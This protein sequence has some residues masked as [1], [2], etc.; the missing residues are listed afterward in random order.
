MHANADI[1]CYLDADARSKRVR[2]AGERPEGT[3]PP[4][5]ARGCHPS[6]VP[7][8]VIAQKLSPRRSQPRHV[9]G[10]HADEREWITRI[11]D[12]R[13]ELAG[14]TAEVEVVDYGARTPELSL[15][16]QEMDRGTAEKRVVGQ[17]C[18]VAANRRP[19]A[20]LLFRLIRE[21]R[22]E[23][24]LQLGTSLGIS[25]AYQAAALEANGRGH[26]VTLEGASALAQIAR[27]NL[28]RIGLDHRVEVVS[29]R[30][31]DTLEKSLESSGGVDYA[32]IDGRHDGDA[33][34]EY[35][36]QLARRMGT[37]GVFVFDDIG[38]SSSSMRRAWASIVTDSR[39]TATASVGD[40][41][42]GSSS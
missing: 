23:R 35:F 40:V 12:L 9:A 28:Q 27:D 19:T 17:I 3:D 7:G 4:T 32:F 2:V 14:S 18:R 31:V 29:G 38:W 42:S 5:D 24:R 8:R 20:L 1:Y 33:T 16:K 21:F 6:A 34:L 25:A 39:V 36:E 41:L 10:S 37:P 11:E 15:S 30:F 22:P 26:L 13:A